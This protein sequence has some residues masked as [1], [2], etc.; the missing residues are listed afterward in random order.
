M[1]PPPPALNIHRMLLW[2]TINP[3]P[4]PLPHSS[5]ER[6][7]LLA[8]G[9]KQQVVTLAKSP[10]RLHRQLPASTS[11]KYE[12]IIKEAI[13]ARG[14]PLASG[15]FIKKCIMENHSSNLPVRSISNSGTMLL[16]GCCSG[17]RVPTNV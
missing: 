10:S 13:Q 3:A 9:P 7:C 16:S 1:H 12:R 11:G 15:I 14:Q 4:I 5:L 2:L 17:G 6:N 8:H